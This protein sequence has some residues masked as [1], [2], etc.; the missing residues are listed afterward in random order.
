[1]SPPLKRG[2]RTIQMDPIRFSHVYLKIMTTRSLR[3]KRI[4]EFTG[5]NNLKNGRSG[6]TKRH[7]F[8]L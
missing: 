7:I 8:S 4:V 1:M 3:K 6:R 5:R 2:V